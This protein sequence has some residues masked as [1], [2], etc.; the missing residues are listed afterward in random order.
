MSDAPAVAVRTS[1]R[2]RSPRRVSAAEVARLDPYTFMATID[3]RVIHP[4]GRASTDTLLRWAGISEASRVLDVG[5]G[6]GT[7][8]IEIARRFARL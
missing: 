6:V 2:P 5:C 4:G 7:T 1:K 8:A 3:K